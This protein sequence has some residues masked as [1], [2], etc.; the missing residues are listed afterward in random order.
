M[1]NWDW[2][3]H[4]PN[5]FPLADKTICVLERPCDKKQLGCLFISNYTGGNRAWH[6]CALSQKMHC[7]SLVVFFSLIKNS[8]SH[9][10]PK[11]LFWILWRLSCICVVALMAQ[12]AFLITEKVKQPLI[13]QGIHDVISC[14]D[15]YT[16]GKKYLGGEPR[17][18]EFEAKALCCWRFARS[19]GR[20]TPVAQGLRSETWPDKKTEMQLMIQ[21]GGWGWRGGGWGW[22]SCCKR[23]DG[24]GIV[25]SDPEA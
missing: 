17:H 24:W 6:N 23:R 11:S 15:L 8:I 25:V 14:H 20:V 18:S 2:A 1:T 13:K 7:K 5:S 21:D 16:L 19:E 3:L 9:K 12:R 22:S 10:W 4:C